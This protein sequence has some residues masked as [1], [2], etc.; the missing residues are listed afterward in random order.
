MDCKK[1]MN[2]QSRRIP[3]GVLL[4]AVPVLLS[5]AATVTS[6]HRPEEAYADGIEFDVTL[7]ESATK[8]GYRAPD[9][10]ET[11]S[12]N[13]VLLHWSQ[14][15][16]I[17]ICG[18]NAGRVLDQTVAWQDYKVSAVAGK[19]SNTQSVATI[20]CV[21]P[22][23]PLRWLDLTAIDPARLYAVYPSPAQL[24]D[25]LDADRL[26]ALGTGLDTDGV[27]TGC[28]PGSQTLVRRSSDP[29][30]AAY[31]IFD[32]PMQFAYLGA[33]K[34]GLPGARISFPFEPLFTAFEFTVCAS[35]AFPEATITRM[36]LYNAGLTLAGAFSCTL[37]DTA[38]VVTQE[39]NG[40]GIEVVFP[41]EGV[42]AVSGKPVVFTV[43]ALG[44]T[45][46]GLTIVF[47]GPAIGRRLL[48][49]KNAEGILSFE[50]R[51]RYRFGELSF[52]STLNLAYGEEID[53]NGLLN[54]GETLDWDGSNLNWGENLTWE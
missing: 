46:A 44:C 6:C 34:T 16:M 37:G 45:H 3:G 50:G 17:R 42:T 7:G 5:L 49:F 14:N 15:D 41:D 27:V 33:T 43:L 29:A 40:E 32:A 53:W 23:N 18:N 12:G 30:E 31:N 39:G 48:T 21:A 2:A 52:P 26:S 25:H 22:S 8:L 28:I 1:Y 4:W 35:D 51:R 19:E 13:R 24:E 36:Q 11:M 38:P 10:N 20:V 47:E 9:G 54:D